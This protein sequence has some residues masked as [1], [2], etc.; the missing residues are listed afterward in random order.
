METKDVIHDLRIKNNWT[1]TYTDPEQMIDF[2]VHQFA[3]SAWPPEQVRAYY[4]EQLPKP[5][6]WQN[7]N[8][9]E[10]EN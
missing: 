1:H 5:S 6:Y 9:D 10:D 7:R 8:A 4:E 2:L 3:G